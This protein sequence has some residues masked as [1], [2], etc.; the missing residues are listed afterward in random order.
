M[1]Q[2]VVQYNSSL[3][4]I[5]SP[6]NQQ[7]KEMNRPPKV[8]KKMK[9]KK[10]PQSITMTRT[11]PGPAVSHNPIEPARTKQ[12]TEREMGNPISLWKSVAL[13]HPSLSFSRFYGSSQA[14]ISHFI[15][16]PSDVQPHLRLIVFRH[17]APARHRVN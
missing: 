14:I 9:G 1:L 10:S 2:H 8:P 4:N 16:E 11:D 5:H 12:C 15:H 3:T 13:F 7:R 6:G 17:L